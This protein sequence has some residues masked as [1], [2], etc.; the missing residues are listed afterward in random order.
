MKARL[1]SYNI[2]AAQL[3]EQHAGELYR[4]VHPGLL[5]WT[6]RLPQ[7]LREIA[8]HQADLLC[9]QEVDHPEQLQPGLAHLG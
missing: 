4:A 3:A 7:L 5:T 1:I 8:S 6:Y 2:L 9:L